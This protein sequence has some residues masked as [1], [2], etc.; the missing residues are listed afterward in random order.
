MPPPFRLFWNRIGASDRL[1]RPEP[2][3]MI[4]GLKVL[5]H[6]VCG[7]WS[8]SDDLLVRWVHTLLFDVRYQPGG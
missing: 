1:E 7:G 4:P 2:I 6:Q 3:T 8:K 5:E